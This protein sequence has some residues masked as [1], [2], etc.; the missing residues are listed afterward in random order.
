MTESSNSFSIIIAVDN[1]AEELQKFLPGLLTLEYD[2]Y[3]VIVV[4]ESSKDN[5]NDVLK[6]LKQQYKNLYS[7]FVPSYHFR[8]DLRRL[9][10][11]IGVKAAKK[12]RIILSDINKLPESATWLKELAD[13]CNVE[14]VIMTGYIKRKKGDVRLKAFSNIDSA[15][16]TIS[17]TEKRRAAN[18]S[19]LLGFIK[20]D[21]DFIVVKA[22]EAHKLLQLFET[23]KRNKL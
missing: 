15:R 7:T 18:K 20:P 2:D 1:Q 12:Q 21:Y 8:K 13:C 17:N 3:E 19:R 4:D 16:K 23:T 5:T 11:T 22:A 6:A 9:A 10:F 14:D